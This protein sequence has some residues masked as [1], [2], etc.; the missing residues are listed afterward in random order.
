M[1]L[2]G[3]HWQLTFTLASVCLFN[4]MPFEWHQLAA[5]LF[6]GRGCLLNGMPLVWHI[7]WQ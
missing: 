5:S 7:S 6:I 3:N 1:P 2:N 4:G